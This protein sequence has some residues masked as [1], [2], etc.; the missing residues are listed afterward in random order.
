MVVE[1]TTIRLP[2]PYD[3]SCW[4]DVKPQINQQHSHDR[5]WFTISKTYP[6]NVT[7]IFKVVKKMKILSGKNDI[8]LIFAQNIDC[9]YTNEYPQSMFWIKN[10]KKMYTHVLLYKRW[11]Q[12]DILFMDMCP[13]NIL[14]HAFFINNNILY[15]YMC[16]STFSLICSLLVRNLS[17]FFV[18]VLF[19]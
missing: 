15:M 6:H 19:H 3:L 13:K 8:F 17:F 9:G 12:G 10:K 16:I 5:S 18:F 14:S 1:V 7:E 2:S 11:V 4:W